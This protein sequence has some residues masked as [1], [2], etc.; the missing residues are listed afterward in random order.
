MMEKESKIPSREAL[1]EIWKENLSMAHLGPL[2]YPILKFILEHYGF[3]LVQLERD[4]EKRKMKCLL[5]FVWLIRFWARLASEKRR[6]AYRLDE[7]VIDDIL[8]G[9]NTLIIVGEKIA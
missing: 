9:G 6:Q 7:T 1:R 8:M 3:R 2:G 4:R 5:P